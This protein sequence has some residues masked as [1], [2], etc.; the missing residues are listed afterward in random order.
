M[1]LFVDISMFRFNV[2]HIDLYLFCLA[3]ECAPVDQL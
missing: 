3:L 2:L 1:L